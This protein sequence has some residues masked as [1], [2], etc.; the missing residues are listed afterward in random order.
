MKKLSSL[1]VVLLSVLLFSAYSYAQIA[2]S[3]DNPTNT[4]PNL[5]ASYTSL[6]D[7]ITALNGVTGMTGPVTLSLA[8]NGTE[9]AP[10]GGYI[11][12]STSL[13]AVTSATNTI[14]F[15]KSGVGA[16]PLITAFTPGTST[17]TDGI[18]KIQGADYIT[19]N[20]ID[21][22]EN[23]A[24]TT[25][26]Q[27]MEW[28][29]ALVKLNATAPFDGC[30]YVNISNCSIT[31]NNTNTATEG[32]HVYNHIAT[33][34]T[35]LTITA[36]TDAHNN[37]T[38]Q[39]CTV[40]N[41]YSG[42]VFN[43]F[44]ASTPYS[45]YDQNILV[46]GCTVQNFKSYGIRTIYENN[47][48]A[49][50]NTINNTAS[51]GAATTVTMYGIMSSTGTTSNF[52]ARGNN[53]Q[54]SRGSITS[55]MYG[56]SNAFT[57]NVIMS[58]NTLSNFV[59]GGSSG[60]V[61][62][63]NNAAT[64]SL[65]NIDSNTIGTSTSVNT[66]G[67][68]YGIYNSSGSNSINIR[69]NTIS[70]ITRITG[71]SGA[72]YGYYN[73]GSPTGGTE[74]F[75]YNTVTSIN[76]SV[77]T[78]LLYG[79]YSNTSSTQNKTV[80]GN[81][82]YSN[83]SG[84]GNQ[85]GLYMLL[86]TT[87]NYYSNNIYNLSGAGGVTGF[88]YSGT[89]V[90]S[91]SNTVYNLSSTGAASA[92]YGI[93][94]SA[95]TTVNSYKNRVYNLSSS[96]A[97]GLVYGFYCLGPT[98]SNLY[99]N[100]ISDIKAPSA[101]GSNAVIGINIGGG[102]NVNLYYNTVYLNAAGGATFGSSAVYKSSTTTSEFRNNIFVNVSTPG[103]TSGS[104]VA[105]RWSGVY[106]AT[107]YTSTSNN[108]CLY[109]GTP[110]AN[111]LIYN[112]GTNS[113][114][115]I[116][117]Y[118]TR[119][120]SRDASSFSEL[121]PF[122]NVATTP[123]D[124]HIQTT[125]P[126]QLEKGG[127]PVS[128]PVAITDD[129]DGNI[130]NVSLPDV[131][132][133]EGDFTPLDMTPPTISYTPLGNTSGSGN[134][135]LTTTITDG[136][137]VPTAGIGL[138]VL[139]WA[140]NSATGPFTSA[141]A[142][143]ISGNQ[144]N[145]S[146]GSGV[147]TNDVVYYYIVAQD[148]VSTPNV[149]AYPS[150]GAGGFTANPPAAATPPTTPSSYLIVPAPLSGDYTVG[151]TLFN[152]ITGK[153]IY[154]EKVV[155]K[156]MK[157]IPVYEE[158]TKENGGETRYTGTK[159][160]EVEQTSWVPME[161]GKKYEGE[162]Y[163]KKSVNPN[164]NFLS[165]TE[166]V[167]ATI[168]AAVADLNLRG[169]SGPVRFLLTDASYTTGET[170]PI[171]VDITSSDLPSAVN[172]VTF[173]PNTGVTASISG[174]SATSIFKLNGADYIIFDGSNTASGTTKDLTINNTAITTGSA[175]IWIA[176]K[177][178][179]LGAT[180]NVIKNCIINGGSATVATTYGIFIGG[181]TIGS[182]GDDND[183][184]TIQNNTIGT[185]YLGIF[186][187]ASSSG[188]LNNLSI[189]QNTLGSLTDASSIG[190]IGIS[191]AQGTGSI[192]SQN[193]IFNVKVGTN[194]KGI[195]IS[196]GFVS[197][198]FSKNKIYAI[199]YTGSTG[200]GGKGFDVNTVN[201]S[202]NLTFDNNLIYDIT[203]DGYSGTSDNICGF[204]LAG[205][206]GYNF[207]YNSV[208]LYGSI[209]RSSATAD[210][211]AAMFIISGVTN[212]DI[213]D[214]IFV[215]GLENTSGVSTSYA[216]Y[217]TATVNTI[218][219][220]IN[221]NDYY[222][223]GVEGVLGYLSSNRSTIADWRTAS[224]QDVNSVSGDPKF[225]NNTNLHI[226]PTDLSPV[227]NA[228]TPIA[229]ITTDYDGNTR[230]VTNPDIGA[231][232]YNYVP[233]SVDPPSGLTATAT[234]STVIDLVWTN[235]G[236]NDAVMLVANTT[237]SF[238]EPINGT[239]YPV[240]YVFPS[241]AVVKYSGI[242]GVYSHTGLSGNT[243]V[244]YKAYS[245]DGSTQY[246]AAIT[247]NATTPFG[248]PYSENFNASTSYPSGWSG[249]MSI[250]A[251]HG[252]S[253]SNG[254][255]KNLYSSVLSCNASGPVIG[256]ATS[257]TN[258][259]FDYRIVNYTSYPSTATVLSSGD[260]NSIQIQ[261]ST[262]GGTNYTTIYTIDYSNHITSTS[263]ATKSL[264]L[265]SYSGKFIK[266]KV[267]GTWGTGDYYV[268]FDNFE[269]KNVS[270]LPPAAFSATAS[271]GTQVDLAF[272]PNASSHNVVI[273]WNSSGTFTDPV[274][275]PPAP[276]GSLAGGTLIYDGTSSPQY[277]TG[278][279]PATTYYYKAFSYNAGEY[280]S[281]LTANATTP[282]G[283]PYTQDFNAALTLPAGWTQTST[284]SSRWTI[285]AST[286]AGGTI[287]EAKATFVSGTGTS[288]LISPPISTTGLTGLKLSFKHLFDTY[289]TGVTYKIQSS[290]N[291][292]SWTDE[293]WV[294][295]SG[296]SNDGP[297]TV[298]TTV[299]NNLGSV[300]YIAFVLDGDHYQLD[301][302]YQDDI[303]ISEIP[304][305]DVG[306]FSVDMNINNIPG[307]VSP[308]ATVKNYGSV[309]QTFPVQM[310][311][312]GGYTS[313][314]T[315]TS[316]A[317]GAT[318]QVTF[319]DWT[320]A[321]GSYTVNVC[322]QLTGDVDAS[323]DCKS[324]DIGVF[325]GTYSSGTAIPAAGATYMGSGVGWT[326]YSVTP[327]VGYLFS[328][329][330]NTAS[331]L[332]TECYKYNTNTGVW[333]AIAS[334]PVK[335]VVLATA[336]VGNYIYAIGGSD[337][338]TPVST[339]YRYDIA[340]DSWTSMASMPI[341]LSWIKATA[342]NNRIYVAGG[343]DGTSYYS[344]VYVYD[345]AANT[346]AAG[347]SMPGARIG[348]AF[349]NVGNTLLYVGGADASTLYSTVYKGIINPANPLDIAWTSALNP[350]PG[351]GKQY[352]GNS[353]NIKLTSVPDK[354]DSESFKKSKD[355]DVKNI[356]SKGDTKEPQKNM[357][358]MAVYPA[359]A[360]YKFDAAPW[361]NDEIIIT[362][363]NG[364]G[365]WTPITPC[366]VY[367]YNPVTDTWTWVG[368][369]NSP[370]LGASIGSVNV[371]SGAN[372]NWRLVV[373]SGYGGAG[374]LTETQIFTDEI[375]PA[376]RTLV[377]KSLLQGLF[378]GTTMLAKN[379][380][381]QLKNAAFTTVESKSFTQSGNGES[382]LN[383]T[384]AANATPYW[385]VVKYD[386]GIETWSAATVQFSGSYLAYDFTTAANK[387]YG[388]NQIL[389]GTKYCI[390]TGD[391]N[392]DGTV[393]LNDAIP[394]LSDYDNLDYHELNDLNLD[395]T[396]DLNDAIFV[397]SGY[398]NLVGS[399]IPSKMSPLKN[400]NNNSIDRK[401]IL[402]KIESLRK[403]QNDI[404]QNDKSINV[405]NT[406]KKGND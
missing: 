329:G 235:N 55:S 196:T 263:F 64:T 224:G 297:G 170:Y 288:R 325:T 238:D 395:A 39:N 28:G 215:N 391:I 269:V 402:D 397:L 73:F 387:A 315:V 82:I 262:N 273:V 383:F 115:T 86:G 320:A 44:A 347:T 18:W 56:I 120:A 74:L 351:N 334:L 386:N 349:S 81:N 180:Y 327:R 330:G 135:L 275:P 123:Y 270:V 266:F 255:Y 146:F 222:A 175:S 323:N 406:K 240:D 134:R 150:G 337:G 83:T 40:K 404:K 401:A 264:S 223:Y 332:G 60:A 5:S 45:L 65:T 359:G 42:I 168:T 3:V 25:A 121:P 158:G 366:P 51:G 100:Y 41:A 34:T 203:G 109:A 84:S 249:D 95:G 403:K 399:V 132:A 267:L 398:D 305:K 57:G 362:G 301:Y 201:S 4:T 179:A 76:N 344:S 13:N 304:A 104:T 308:K 21:L 126:T 209:S 212:L 221:Y 85:I 352:T 299:L 396:I 220:N 107:Y 151:T 260:G 232:E 162:L 92:I 210:I 27:Q 313:T 138:P 368:A 367:K 111:M 140:I 277:H 167:Y 371:G 54:L 62:F 336:V 342:Y 49:V 326:D 30:Q 321:L 339:V 268:D 286:N 274:G 181:A 46:S 278:L 2:V 259:L 310:T 324:K 298:T 96:T 136:T 245:Y 400:R 377:V 50:N 38:I 300:T 1:V 356:D 29:Y 118:K 58:G 357:S 200:Y 98:T 171:T 20:G 142:S 52:T 185:A 143:Y 112:D 189:T 8:A 184:I 89:T 378:D 48:A 37:I 340:G 141:T 147:V 293:A 393:D 242:D 205:G 176:S 306:T 137:G 388:D 22:Q 78:G 208:N 94:P 7:A 229:G 177:G 303:S 93:Y 174:S 311:I 9:T 211:S 370:E 265:S 360:L 145:F 234:N 90:N 32:I 77:S 228:G 19:I 376:S 284:L 380:T 70:G 75:A 241:G 23:A 244:Y 190:N 389:I 282:Y 322:T 381:V 157:E 226:N 243:T 149:G 335:K 365:G 110:A 155:T 161:N 285:A 314:K 247:A 283:L 63:I 294:N 47:F 108:N 331:A 99:N 79:L 131:G 231:D 302:W 338:T 72:F 117:A 373:G 71:T 35:S 280:S 12:G 354:K 66:T 348:G 159:M 193:E 392:Q 253:S 290:S 160:T 219:T 207:Y 154:F 33:A 165:G 350:Y 312:T 186:A 353:E 394:I 195:L 333:T 166:G 36:V 227:N 307:T 291:L 97:G 319:D 102:T 328:I 382:T 113:D 206:G 122:V 148:I 198:T 271:S 276:G 384:V 279:S 309:A 204:R 191:L 213:R 197:S 192:V 385:I 316:L 14:T 11:L 194:A 67:S 318:T 6:A 187:Q 343:Y 236:N 225:V 252:A 214:N 133:D 188:I 372:H 169:V 26:T 16:N 272:T 53:I 248:I 129:Y 164:L 217:T 346:W 292:T 69:N 369:L 59:A 345:V 124:L 127:S 61:Y 91:Y 17:T 216:I 105:L 375:V 281:G 24:N 258:L 183:Y 43:G 80:F 374:T 355:K 230:N 261:I 287:N 130:R 119:V 125:I 233:P 251:T 163:A 237:N 379:C 341:A 156:V 139:Y 363:G 289:G 390:Y 364:D 116:G 295:A 101:T 10:A 254:L 31:L 88:Q 178:T 317:P 172:T 256:T 296:S 173:K 128:T 246:S 199:R 106:N 152:Q 182:T 361:G 239:S 144:Y 153:N 114:Q 250:S 15:I 257:N 202:S 68:I 218:F 405:G 358:P 103:A 87:C